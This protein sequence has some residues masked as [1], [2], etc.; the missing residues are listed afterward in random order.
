MRVVVIGAAGF[1]GRAILRSFSSRGHETLGLVHTP[2]KARIVRSEGGHPVV[3]DLLD[4]STLVA[5]LR[6]AD[7]AIHVAQPSEGSLDRMREVRVRGAQ[8]LVAAARTTGVTRLLLGSGYWVYRDSPEVI[9]E[10]SPLA[11]ISISRVNFDCEQVGRTAADRGDLEMMVVRPG[12]VYGPGSWFREMVSEIRDGRYR[13]IE[14]GANSLSP[15]H[16]ADCGEAFRTIAEHW[17]N[18]ETYLVVDD[19]PVSTRTF[20]EFVA[21]QL[22]APVVRTLSFARAAEEWGEDLARLNAASRPASNR[23]LRALGW[24]PRYASYRAGIP[25]VLEELRAP[26][27]GKTERR[28]R[29]GRSRR[30]GKPL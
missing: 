19:Q 11:P 17:R 22:G 18:G 3:A 2:D 26:G 5:P 14:P 6:G 24:E 8:N 13:Y 20:A 27:S 4:P 23:K 25:R 15:V 12:M 16:L 29:T 21:Q 30:A 28:G 1:L 9:S 7:L 10:E